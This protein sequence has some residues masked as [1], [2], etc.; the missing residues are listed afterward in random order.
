MLSISSTAT[1]LS[2]LHSPRLCPL[3]SLAEFLSSRVILDPLCSL[4]CWSTSL[5]KSIFL[6]KTL[7]CILRL[8]SFVFYYCCSY[9]SLNL[10][11]FSQVISFTNLMI[12]SNLHVCLFPMPLLLLNKCLLPARIYCKYYLET[13]FKSCNRLA[14]LS[15]ESSW[16]LFWIPILKKK[17]HIYLSALAMWVKL[18][19]SSRR[20]CGF[21]SL[22]GFSLFLSGFI[23][24]KWE[25]SQVSS[26]QSWGSMR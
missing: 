16:C 22:K 9:W 17:N 4:L 26:P 25:R 13:L 11:L 10:I 24:S 12:I 5:S 19:S 18:P 2:S 6:D 8:F 14:I 21:T 7:S 15:I 3:L 20:D 23:I 1:T